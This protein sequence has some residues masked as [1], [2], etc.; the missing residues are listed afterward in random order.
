MSHIISLNGQFKADIYNKNDELVSE[1]EYSSNFITCSGL[2]YPLTM[3]FA[4]TFK[5]LSL[6]S[7][8]Q[9]N[10]LHT[11]G[12]ASGC[13]PYIY[14]SAGEHPL[15]HNFLWTTGIVAEACGY[16]STFTGVELYRGWRIPE[17]L[18]SFL[19]EDLHVSELMTTP[20]STGIKKYTKRGNHFNDIFSGVTAFSRIL[21]DFTIPSGDY[22]VITYKLDFTIDS[23]VQTFSPFIGLNNAVGAS[24]EAWQALT[25]VA[26]VLHPGIRLIRSSESAST[27]GGKAGGGDTYEL[28]YGSPLEPVQT[29]NLYAYFS[30]DNTQFRFDPYWGGSA[31]TNLQKLVKPSDGTLHWN[32]TGLHIATGLPEYFWNFPEVLEDDQT[33]KVDDANSLHDLQINPT[34]VDRFEQFRRPESELP[35][36]SNVTEEFGAGGMGNQGYNSSVVVTSVNHDIAIDYTGQID[37]RRDRSLTRVLGWQGINAVADPANPGTFVKYKSLVFAANNADPPVERVEAVEDGDYAFF[38]SQFGT[39]DSTNHPLGGDHYVNF[40]STGAWP[41]GNND[42]KPT[43]TQPSDPYPYQDNQNGMSVTWRL[44]WSAPCGEVAGSC[45]K[46]DSHGGVYVT[47]ATCEAANG[48]WTDCVDP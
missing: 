38:D 42:A 26:R 45:S 1:G 25:G 14:S 11:T 31:K 34:R 41:Y 13:Q 5:Y 27:A 43:F 9:P 24:K 6:G 44:S 3:P 33:E 2:N 22:G 40:N 48:V 39:F 46:Y 19:E 32:T 23:A 21:K 12:L 7:G 15:K 18:G 8:K 36:A 28:K 47:K 37:Y 17:R 4:D 20:A 29:G 10:H 30:S 16:K 35:E